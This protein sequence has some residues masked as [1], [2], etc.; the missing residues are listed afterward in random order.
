MVSM[1]R[2]LWITAAAAVLA[3]GC[4]SA[5]A[6][7]ASSASSA[8]ASSSVPAA[9]A[10]ADALQAALEA[11]DSW[12]SVTTA[13]SRSY[14]MDYGEDQVSS[15]YDMD[16]V[17]EEAGLQGDS[18]RGHLHQY[19]HSGGIESELEGWYLDGRLYNTYN[20]VNFYEDMTFSSFEESILMPLHP[21]TV[22][23]D[24]IAA[25]DVSRS[26][27]NT[28]YTFTLDNEQAADIFS[29]H[30]DAYGLADYEDYAVTSAWIRQTL[31]G[32]GSLVQ[33]ETQFVC[34]VTYDGY[35]VTVTA[36]TQASWMDA[37]NTTVSPSEEEQAAMAA[38]VSYQDIDTSTISDEET[39]DD[40]AEDTV[41]ATFKKRLCSRLGYTLQEDG[42]YKTE[43]NGTESYT[44]DFEHYQFIY[45]NRSSH[46]VYNW[47]G[48]TGGFS[49]ICNYDFASDTATTDCDSSVVE[50]IQ[51]VKEDFMMELYYCGLSLE[52]LQA[53]AQ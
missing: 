6:E 15:I 14:T 16:G 3:A 9:P 10:S 17:V 41:T 37:G 42:T 34:T 50:M 43:F 33:E 21:Y 2:K 32:S 45:G 5:A 8:A 12:D 51:T 47:K 1:L 27:E 29:T 11:A 25:Q 49:D 20:G 28:V 38:Y 40:S 31:D 53:E 7:P 39:L 19:I 24:A 18:P 44:I 48:D 22:P 23:Q 52:D 26:G 4:G 30:Y 13:F 35:Q 36:E 46:Y